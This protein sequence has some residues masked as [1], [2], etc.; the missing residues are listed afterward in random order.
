MF[1]SEK[2]KWREI[3]YNRNLRI[4]VK[5]PVTVRKIL[6]DL[7]GTVN[8]LFDT[9][10]FESDNYTP[11]ETRQI[12]LKDIIYTKTICFVKNYLKLF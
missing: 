11:V 10:E 5:Q 8:G 3:L 9:F 2:K 1:K 7:H 6:T 12:Y 4:P